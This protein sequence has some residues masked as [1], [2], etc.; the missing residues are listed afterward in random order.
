[1]TILDLN[2]WMR[3]SWEATQEM[4]CPPECVWCEVPVAEGNHFCGDCL[5]HFSQRLLPMPALRVTS[6][7]GRAKY[8]LLFDARRPVGDFLKLSP[9]D[10]I[11]GA[12][13]KR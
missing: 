3:E 5:S 7:A 1:M 6:P 4:L 12:C 10:L 9:W 2:S 11:E 8:E 13:A